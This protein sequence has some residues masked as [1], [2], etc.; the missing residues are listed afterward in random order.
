MGESPKSA[1]ALWVLSFFFWA[2]RGLCVSTRPPNHF[3]ATAPKA[4]LTSGLLRNIIAGCSASTSWKYLGESDKGSQFTDI[5]CCHVFGVMG[6]QSHCRS[7]SRSL[8]PLCFGAWKR[9]HPVPEAWFAN[10]MKF[11]L[12]LAGRN[13]IYV[14][15]R[16]NNWRRSSCD[17]LSKSS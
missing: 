12:H 8:R 11:W 14:N 15:R 5:V 16:P 2:F 7:K 17:E 9:H 6:W 1:S 3:A 4:A 13:T 10:C